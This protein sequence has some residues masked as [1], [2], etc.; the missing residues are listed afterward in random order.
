MAVAVFGG[1]KSQLGL[2][3]MM[4][5]DLDLPDSKSNS[6]WF[7]DII[8][9]ELPFP[10]P[11]ILQVPLSTYFLNDGTFEPIRLPLPNPKPLLSDTE[12]TITSNAL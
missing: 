3:G 4:G 5:D 7:N 9:C 12:F 8:Y 2:G 6:S 10:P 1:S 11:L